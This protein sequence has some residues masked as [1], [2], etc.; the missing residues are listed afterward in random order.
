MKRAWMGSAGIVALALAVPG[1]PAFADTPE[2]QPFAETK[3]SRK[4][5]MARGGPIA[6]GDRVAGRLEGASHTYTLEARAG[7]RLQVA[8]TSDQ[9]DP[10]LT[11]TG[12]GD[13]SLENDDG[14]DGTLNSA[15]DAR[16][17]AAG[18]YRIVVGS[19]QGSGSGD[20]R[21]STIDPA[22]PVPAGVEA[23]PLTLGEPQSGLL[24]QSDPVRLSGESVDYYRFAGT[25]GQRVTLE[26]DSE[27]I[28][29]FLTLYL[30]DGRVETN[31]DRQ[32]VEDT[33]SRLTIRLPLDGTYTLGA[34]TYAP[35]ESGAYTVRLL[36]AAEGVRTVRPASGN[37]QVHALSVGVAGY[38]RTSPLERTDED[39][40]RVTHALREAGV[41][42]PG[43]VTLTEREATRENFT[44][45]LADLAGRVGPDD[46]LLIFFSGH[47]EKVENMTTER[48]GS[49]ETIELFDAALHDFELAAMME[50]VT[51]RTLLVIDAC[52]S[53]GFDQVIDM[54][55]NRMGVF[56]S[57]ADTLSLVA[58]K[59]KSGGYIS[60]I[61]RQA[62][63]GEGDMNGDGA[64]EAGELSEFMRRA[65]Y[66]MVLAEPLLTDAEDFR[67]HQ[68]PGYQHIIVDRGG[69]GMPFSEV[70]M[71]FGSAAP[72][73]IARR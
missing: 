3:Q 13:F 50:G 57:D 68:V 2:A 24:V 32:G 26:L 28:D 23:Q 42:A 34:S 59:E 67:D 20:Y 10:V 66:R 60:A 16:L 5:V 48:D 41:L 6:A 15:L 49:A 8:L 4:P 71:D 70:L 47:G 33:N 12:P 19:F 17:P 56:S 25:E 63:E 31:D 61:F 69:D 55:D 44:A 65:F 14:P 58:T 37:A 30:P 29:T 39:A 9:F 18:T 53:G 43:S 73:A 11:I 45:A 64:V 27:Q 36:E 72:S 22:N 21:L 51:A 1:G 46:T 54:A 35:G 62:L 38:E 40:M 52:Y 7:Q